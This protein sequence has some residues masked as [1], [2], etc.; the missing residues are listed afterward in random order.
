MST[1]LSTK[2]W[3]RRKMGSLADPCTWDIVPFIKICKALCMLLWEGSAI[4]VSGLANPVEIKG[5]LKKN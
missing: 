5:N 4:P 1:N 2:A 3:W